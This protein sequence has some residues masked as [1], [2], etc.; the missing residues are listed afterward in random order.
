[1]SHP[2][3]SGAVLY[4]KNVARVCTFYQEVAGLEMIRAEDDHVVLESPVFQLVILAVPAA[5]AATFEVA[6]PP[7][8]R[9]ETPIKLFFPVVS[10]DEARRAAARLGGGLNPADRVWVYQGFNICDGYDPEGNVV[11]FRER[12]PGL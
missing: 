11:Q 5:I 12:G 2:S 8:P 7:I 3:K 9:T 6:T 4:A 10:I 1:M